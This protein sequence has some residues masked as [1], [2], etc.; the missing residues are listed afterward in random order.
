MR[1]KSSVLGVAL[2]GL[3]SL[4]QPAWSWV[5][6]TNNNKIDDGIEAVQ[7]QG[8][9]AAYEHGDVNARALFF[10]YPAD[11]PA[12]TFGVFGPMPTGFIPNVIKPS[13]PGSFAPSLVDEPRYMSSKMYIQE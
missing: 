6:D 5:R 13:G 10:V 1:L 9:G 3:T 8:L 11:L 7:T 4:A 2:L 12:M